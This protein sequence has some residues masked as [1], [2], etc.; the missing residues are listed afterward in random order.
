MSK[1]VSAGTAR[2]WNCMTGGMFHF[3]GQILSC[4]DFATL[5]LDRTVTVV[6]RTQ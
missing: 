6:V 3:D 4:V 1:Q 5:E 2:A